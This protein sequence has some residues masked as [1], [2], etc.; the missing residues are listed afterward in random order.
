[1]KIT[2]AK[3][4]I[5]GFLTISLLLILISISSLY[6]LNSIGA[7]TDEVN[8]TAIPTISGS[9]TLKATFLNMGRLTFESYI[10]EELSGLNEKQESFNK[11]KATFDKT[12]SQLNSIVSDDPALKSSLDK[13]HD[14]YS[15]Y[16]GVIIGA[17]VVECQDIHGY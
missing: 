13:V 15:N 8:N 12:Y 11:S 10:E 16:I 4:I 6:N 1:M 9:N 14:S 5:G 2:V 17:W 3:R 7:A